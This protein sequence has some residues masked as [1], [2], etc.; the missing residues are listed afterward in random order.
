MPV[1]AANASTPAMSVSCSFASFRNAIKSLIS[2]GM[3]SC[4]MCFERGSSKLAIG[5][6]EIIRRRLAQRSTIQQRL[7]LVGWQT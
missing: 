2:G 4:L 7:R 5:F 3:T 6:R 1:V